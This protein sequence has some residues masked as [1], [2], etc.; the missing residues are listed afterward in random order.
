MVKVSGVWVSPL[1]IE[2]RLHGYPGVRECAALGL[3]NE[4]G[5][6]TIKA[7][8]VFEPGKTATAATQDELKQFCKT[9]LGPHKYPAI[10]QILDELPKTGQGKI[11]RR[12][13]REL[14]C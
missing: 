9:K 3:Q 6:T 12:L 2:Q 13:L 8:V 10:I 11:D 7:F 5:L 14:T 4:D 1:E